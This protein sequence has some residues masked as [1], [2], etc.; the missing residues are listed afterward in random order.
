MNTRGKRL[1]GTAVDDGKIKPD[2]LVDDSLIWIGFLASLAAGAATGVG[3]R[4]VFLPVIRISPRAQ[5]VMLGFAA[6]VMLAASTFSLILIAN[7]PTGPQ[8]QTAI[9]SPG[10]M[11][12]F[13]AP[14]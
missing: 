5:D 13:S 12:Q 4:P 7:C 8:P 9:V 14:M 3:A 2:V 1:S 10:S 11:S 6:G